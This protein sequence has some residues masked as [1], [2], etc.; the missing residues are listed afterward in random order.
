MSDDKTKAAE[1][2]KVR[3]EAFNGELVPL[4]GKYKIGLG[5]EAFI[6][7][8]GRV[9]ARPVLFDDIKKEEPQAEPEAPKEE[10]K[11]EVTE[12]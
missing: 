9:L 12:A 1:D 8:D 3:T 4:L 2:L 7:R 11:S 6:T 5:G 10:E